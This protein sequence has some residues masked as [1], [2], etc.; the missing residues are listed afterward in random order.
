MA[1]QAA[2]SLAEL[3]E[4]LGVGFAGD[5]ATR[6]HGL[7]TLK[8]AG[9]GQL[10]FFHNSR[11]F[12]ALLGTRA[13]AVILR[14]DYLDKCPTNALL[15]E[16]PYIT[17]AQATRLFEQR[18]SAPVGIHPSA[19]IDPSAEIDP[20]ASISPHVVVGA[21]AR[22]GAN[23]S[24]G[25]HCS[26]GDDSVI[27]AG[28]LLNANV[29]LY[30]GVTVG[31]R[32]VIHAGVV[33]GS[34]GF[35]FAFDGERHLKIAQLGGVRIGDDVEIGSGTCIDR[36]A[37]EDTEIG[38]GVKIDNLVQIAHN[39]KVGAHT[40]ICGCSAIAGSS[41]IGKNCIIAGGVGIINHLTIADGVTVTAMSLVSQSIG[42]KG[43]YSS[44][45]GLA[46]TL[47]WRRNMVRFGQLDEMSKRLRKLEK[48]VSTSNTKKR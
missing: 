21:R 28:S 5:A 35:G 24:I 14:P 46:D 22:I 7:A 39:V 45:T 42:E 18:H 19:V 25:P 3:A 16:R 43:V 6:L 1:Q 10:S 41:R 44:G 15:S 30:H 31:E 27:G 34:D 40:V 36:G 32:A 2:Y 11:Y 4:R 9:P 23:V 17:F 20:S 29:T 38:D 13:S 47:T 37:L 33:I 8:G 26:I 48:A 12:Q